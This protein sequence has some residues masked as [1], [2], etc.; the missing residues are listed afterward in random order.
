MVTDDYEQTTLM[1]NMQYRQSTERVTSPDRDS[2]IESGL[3]GFTQPHDDGDN[4]MSKD[5]TKG[6]VRSRDL[7][8]TFTISQTSFRTH[9]A[10]G[11]AIFLLFLVAVT[12]LRMTFFRRPPLSRSITTT[13]MVKPHNYRIQASVFCKLR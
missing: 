7:R 3:S 11:A 6:R 10:Y 2:D 9:L 13:K 8:F 5:G 1:S 4:W 12:L